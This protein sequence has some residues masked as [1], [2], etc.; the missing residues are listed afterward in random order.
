[1]KQLV[2]SPKTGEL[3]I[4]EVAS[5]ALLRGHLLVRTRTS[6]VSAGTERLAVG[7]AK[8]S[9]L[10]KAKA[11]PDLAR[12][13]LAKLKRDG[14]AATAAAIRGRL[15][16]ALPLGY[17]AAGEVVAVGTG[18]AGRFRP[19]QRVAAAGAGVANHAE[20]NLVPANLAAPVP[21]GVDFEAA[22]YATVGAI[23]L[24]AVRQSRPEFGAWCAVVGVGLV[25]QLAA[26]FLALSG[27]RVLALDFDADR[28]ALATRLGA[29]A[30]CDLGTQD[31]A[32]V[33]AAATKNLGCDAVIIAAATPSSL[34]FETA[35]Q[36][37][38][39]R[40][41]VAVVGNT[42]TAFPYREFMA[43]ELSLVVSRSYG[44]GRYD[45]D[46]ETHGV[47]YPP[48]YVRWTETANLAAALDAMRPNRRLRLEPTALTSHR[49]P[50][51]AAP[52]AYAM[53]AGERE[54]HLGVVLQYD[55]GAPSFAPDIEARQPQRRAA[56][57]SHAESTSPRRSASGRCR[58]GVIGG[59]AYARTVLL[60]ILAKLP[61]CELHTLA[62]ARGI[63]A[64]HTRQ[65]LGFGRAT[66]N[67]DEIF[68]DEDIDA[69][70]VATPHSL[71]AAQAA[72]ALAAG[73]PVLVEKP[74][75]LTRSELSAVAAAAEASNA[76]ALVGFNR[77]FAPLA[78]A[79]AAHLAAMPGSRHVLL[80]VNAGPLPPDSWQRR[81]DE[82]GGRLVGEACHFIDLAVF[83]GGAPIATVY[84]QAVPTVDPCEDATIVLELANGSLAT[85]FYTALGDAA[86][87]KELIE[88]YAGGGVARIEDFRRLTLASRGRSQH[89]RRRQDKG[90]AAQLRAFVAAVAAGGPA[91]APW[92]EQVNSSAATLAAVESLAAGR[93][94]PVTVP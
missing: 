3:T 67:A 81:Q 74:L 54:P 62:T 61:G 58:L 68:D 36:V 17:S 42:G 24:H 10:A 5:P 78:G 93:R 88:A 11:R 56:A 50:F 48:G 43:K 27:V 84:A 83:L 14:I 69:V 37:A 65:R 44:P 79:A 66:A 64:A 76:F 30:V 85:V 2:L 92:A 46:Y 80:R 13:T 22:C 89:I 28:L 94:L 23:A 71:H 55:E 47:T 77:R 51:D 35:A 31:A 19:G 52:S 75:A 32:A 57:A 40:A 39:D 86:A 7:F 73:K 63:S 38:R 6:L 59:G 72:Q 45:Q 12:Q 15:D 26:Q 53:I 70:I 82:G 4:A 25:G 49:F 33:A 18:L 16:E 90:H 29:D 8:K 21:A 20:L 34:P 9:L 1:M 41:V 91:P 87:G 60:P